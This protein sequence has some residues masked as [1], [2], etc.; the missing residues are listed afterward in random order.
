[1]SI[2]HLIDEHFHN[3]NAREL[4]EALYAYNDF[5]AQDG[6]MMITLAGAL[7]TAGVG[8]LLSRM[9]RAKKVH[10]ICCTGANLEE[11]FFRL[12]G[13]SQ[14]ISLPKYREN[15]LQCEEVLLAKSLNRV[16]DV[17]IPESVVVDAEGLIRTKWEDAMKSNESFFPHEYIFQALEEMLTKDPQLVNSENSWLVAAMKAKIPV[18][19][20]GWEDSTLG[21]IFTADCYKGV[22]KTSI[23]KNGVDAMLDLIDWYQDGV[24]KNKKGFFQIGGGIAGDFPICVTP[25]IIKD[26]EKPDTPKWA[27]FC[28]ISEST[29]S[30]G[31]YSGAP[32][33]EKITWSKLDASTP[34][35]MIESD[36]TIVVPLLFAALLEMD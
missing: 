31:S 2:K 32:P 17:A 21:N 34:Q 3:F 8:G 26:L 16:T 27:Y 10:A 15:S 13:L 30:Y 28:Q 7:S 6:H 35:F 14:Y 12:I 22:L 33:Q 20:P 24:E 4:K 18:Y 19:V 1:M 9:I 23:M 25:L 29:T 11:D 36:A 5:L